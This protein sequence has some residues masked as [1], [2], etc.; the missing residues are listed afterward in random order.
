MSYQSIDAIQKLLSD[1]IFHYTKDKKKAA[2]RALGTIVEII[3][4]YLLKQWQLDKYTAIERPLSEFGNSEITHNVEFTLHPTRFIARRNIAEFSK[5]TSKSII[6]QFQL[7]AANPKSGALIDSKSILK[8]AFTFAI[9][10]DVFYNVYLHDNNVE[11]YEL[12]NQPLAMIECKRV[13]VEEG[14]SKGP[15]TIE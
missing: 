4:Y 13:G 14:M 10:K 1:E 15:Q 5:L 12:D 8:N 3:T 7:C 11:I 6:S 2:G 9:G